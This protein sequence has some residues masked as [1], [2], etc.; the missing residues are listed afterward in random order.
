MVQKID[1][2]LKIPKP[3]G[4]KLK[5][6]HKRLDRAKKRGFFSQADEHKAAEWASCAIGERSMFDEEVN[7]DIYKKVVVKASYCTTEKGIATFD[8]FLTKKAKKLGGDL[9]QFIEPHLSHD[10]EQR[11]EA[12]RKHI[13]KIENLRHIVTKQFRENTNQE[14]TPIR[15]VKKGREPLQ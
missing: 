10:I 3:K 8:S 9:P 12:A 2:T 4:V 15:K 6:W 7:K 14:I 5:G 11:V 1:N 13:K